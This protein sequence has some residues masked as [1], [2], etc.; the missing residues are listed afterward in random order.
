MRFQLF[1]VV[2]EVR[3]RHRAL[4]LDDRDLLRRRRDIQPH[5]VE[6][7]CAHLPHRSPG[8]AASTSFMTAFKSSSHG[9]GV[10]DALK[11]RPASGAGSSPAPSTS[12]SEPGWPANEPL[13]N[14]R[15]RGDLARQLHDR[16]VDD[17]TA[18]VIERDERL[19]RLHRIGERPDRAY[20]QRLRAWQ[21]L[22]A[23]RPSTSVKNVSAPFG[24]DAAARP[25]RDS[26]AGAWSGSRTRRRCALHLGY[27]RAQSCSPRA[28]RSARTRSTSSR[29]HPGALAPFAQRLGARAHLA[30]IRARAVGEHGVDAG[31]VVG[32]DAVADRARAELLLAVMPPIVA[33]LA[34]EGSTG[35]KSPCCSS[36]G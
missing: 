35:K 25:C 30:E 11:P 9:H 18:T 2:G 31:D 7:C 3:Q 12:S 34:V 13:E 24:A 5:D 22:Q 1:G 17:F 27:A 33:R 15:E 21:R 19:W 4:F 36:R 16:A 6:T 23:S 26:P 28:S 29:Y 14:R 10:V 20:A 32:H 8:C